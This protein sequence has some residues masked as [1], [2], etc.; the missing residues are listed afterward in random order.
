MLCSS[1]NPTALFADGI[2]FSPAEGNALTPMTVSITGFTGTNGPAAVDIYG[3]G[4]SGNCSSAR[5]CTFQASMGYFSGKHWV[6]ASAIVDGVNVTVSN[7]FTVR[8]AK[9]FLNR[10]CGTNGMKVIVTGY[11]F[12][13]NQIVTVD[14]T[15]AQA[16]TNGAFAVNVTL[17]GPPSGPYNL[18]AQDGFHFTTNQI[19][20]G[21]NAVCDSNVGQATDAS[22][23]VTITRPGGQ[24]VPLNPGDPIREG[25]EIR[26][27]AGGRYRIRLSDGT[28]VIL[29]PNG[30]LKIDSY[31]F[32]PANSA[33]DNARFSLLT[34]ALKYTSGLIG[35]QDDNL[36]VNTSYG[37]LGI[38]GT[39]FISRRDP[40]STTQEVYL[41]HGQLAIKPT[42]AS[43]TNIVTAPATIFYDATNVW[44]SGLTQ[45][46]YDA[47]KNEITETNIIT[48][49]PWL[50]QY[51][52][53]TNDNPA[54][55]AAADPDG[56]GQNNYAEFLT[57]TDPTTNASAFKL[58][59]AT[60]EGAGVRLL[61]QTHGGLTNVVQAAAS[62]GGNFA[63]ISP[64]LVI[65]GDAAVTTNFLDEGVLTNA[66]ARFYR[67]RLA[68]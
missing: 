23:G 35:K 7:Y 16:D 49:G 34:G 24:P 40:C 38:R 6:T 28:E 39:E 8:D 48:F 30:R 5:P 36:Q 64:P 51:F 20:L 27:G 41:I 53:C 42:S 4:F 31:F 61:W 18:V 2:S 11:D 9:S 13:R 15:Q 68:P 26:T 17:N 14:N 56:D 65:A 12:G 59:G 29:A 46:A 3:G 66:P 63:D 43:G 57:R 21:T 10:T 60:R 54:A 37:S 1:Q 19:T 55:A 58:L 25:D 45:E 33:S 44:T 47:L 22:G 62:G 32:D 67:I 50:V 52:G